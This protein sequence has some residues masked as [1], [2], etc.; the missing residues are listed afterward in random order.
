MK[1]MIDR[2]EEGIAVLISIDDETLR[3][4]V[5][6]LLLPDGSRE[7]DILT[8]TCERDVKATRAAQERVSQFIDRLKRTE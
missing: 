8:I 7:G 1:A 4:N 3:V 5:P 6:V 2:I